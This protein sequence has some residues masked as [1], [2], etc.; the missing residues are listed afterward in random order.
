MGDYGKELEY[1]RKVVEME[2]NVYNGYTHVGLGLMGLKRYKEALHEL[3]TAVHLKYCSATLFR[4]GLIYG[5]MGEKVKAREVLEKMKKL[6][7]TQSVGSFDMGVVCI[8]MAD[9]NSAFRYFE[10]A[11]E[12]HEG[13]MLYLKCYI[14][15][16]PEFEKDP[17]TK[18]LLEKMGLPNQ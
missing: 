11:N 3:D 12:K 7:S 8:A 13:L 6:R 17:R 16:F 10:E 4:L 1:G 9:F 2:P 5:V 18:Q 14:R 15:N